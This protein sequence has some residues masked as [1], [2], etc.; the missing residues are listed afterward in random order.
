MMGTCLVVSLI[1]V[2]SRRLRLGLRGLTRLQVAAA[3]TLYGGAQVAMWALGMAGASVAAASWLIGVAMGACTVP[4]LTAWMACYDLDFRSIMFYGSFSA[5]ASV[6]LSFVMG[7]LAPTVAALVWC[8]CALVGA[9][10]PVFIGGA[11]GKK[12]SG[13]EALAASGG[14]GSLASATAPFDASDEGAEAPG[15][16]LAAVADLVS[17]IWIPL[18]GLLLCLACSA[19]VEVSVDGQMVRGEYVGLVVAGSLAVGLCCLKVSTPFVLLVDKIVV[20]ALVAFAIL[21]TVLPDTGLGVSAGASLVFVPLMFMAIY[22]VA[23]TVSIRGY[24]RPFVA[25]TVLAACCLAML[26]GSAIKWQTTAE[27]GNGPVMHA[28]IFV[29]YAIIVVDLG[30]ASWRTLV[31]R[32]DADAEGGASVP[33]DAYGRRVDELAAAHDLTP[34]EAQVLLHLAGGHSS[35]YIAKTLFISDNTV[36]T[37]TRN[38]YRKLGVGSREELLVLVGEG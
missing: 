20:P 31:S 34:R 32:P 16:L 5:V 15:G 36:R 1:F 11:A 30:Y 33:R 3:A 25:G 13:G 19:M 8:L 2:A 37:H 6:A 4:L 9:F 12:G 17:T 14:G 22:A 35:K 10:A 38:I 26:V 27:D 29:Y 18:L 28:L 7:L 24:S 21:L 23:S